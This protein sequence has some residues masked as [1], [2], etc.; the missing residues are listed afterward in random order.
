MAHAGDAQLV[1]LVVL[2]HAGEGDAVV[3]LVDHHF[4]SDADL[5][6]ERAHR[7]G[8]EPGGDLCQCGQRGCLEPIASG[9]GILA[10]VKTGEGAEGIAVTPD[11]AEVWV[12][13]RAADTI[14]VRRDQPTKSK[15]VSPRYIRVS[16]LTASPPPDP[17]AA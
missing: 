16:T 5:A 12:T 15:W 8:V 14:S 3:D 7:L 4:V 9:G 17:L 11:G 10:Q 13:N 2:A 1:E 6:A